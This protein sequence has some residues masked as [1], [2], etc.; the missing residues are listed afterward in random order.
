MKSLNSVLLSGAEVLPLIEGGKGVSITT[1]S[2][3]GAWAAGGG[4]GTFSGVNAD[5][6]DS[7][8]DI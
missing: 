5:Y 1:G 3:S 6:Y 7:N 4:V 2:S 8:G